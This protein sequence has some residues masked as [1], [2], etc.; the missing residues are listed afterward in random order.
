MK[1]WIQSFLVDTRQ[2]LIGL[3]DDNGIVKKLAKY[4]VSNLQ[5][6]A[7]VSLNNKYILIYKHCF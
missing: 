2:L 5:K 4:N 1:W 6:E 7:Q 3:R